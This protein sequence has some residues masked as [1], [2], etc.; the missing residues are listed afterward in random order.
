MVQKILSE[1]RA[2]LLIAGF[3]MVC[4]GAQAD[5]PSFEP[6]WAKFKTAVASKNA[7]EVAVNS[8]FPIEMPYGMDPIVDAKDLQARYSELFDGESDASVCFSSE[9][10][11]PRDG[12]YEI[13]CGLKDGDDEAGKPIVYLFELVK[14]AWKFVGLDNANE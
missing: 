14:G 2:F 7:T 8:R 9:A 10:P 11:E 4:T 1:V 5:G 6:F 3:C 13:A 12:H